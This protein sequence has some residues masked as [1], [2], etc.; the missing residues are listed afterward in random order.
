M[1]VGREN[2]WLYPFFVQTDFHHG[3]LGDFA[4]SGPPKYE[5]A[6]PLR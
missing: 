1:S 6:G 4:A 2:R 5:I 3:L